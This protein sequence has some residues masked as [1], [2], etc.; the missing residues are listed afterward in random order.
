MNLNC[1][2][3]AFERRSTTKHL[4]NLS[5]KPA[6]PPRNQFSTAYLSYPKVG[7]TLSQSLTSAVITPLEACKTASE[8]T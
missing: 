4:A 6:S 8:I 2:H 1:Y 7:F 3:F 5:V